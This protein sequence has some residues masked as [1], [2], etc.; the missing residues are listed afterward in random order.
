MEPNSAEPR[1]GALARSPWLRPIGALVAPGA[2][3]RALRDR[4][5][6]VAP[7]LVLLV[8]YV[9]LNLT[10]MQRMDMAAVMRSSMEARGQQVDEQQIQHMAELQGR[11]GLGCSVVGMPVVLLVTALLLMVLVN[12]AGGEATF[13]R[14]WSV[15]LHGL[16][17]M[18]VAWL[19]TL[20][21]VLG[22][23][24]ITLAD[25]Q[26]GLL[27]SNLALLAPADA[28]RVTV[29]LLSSVD[30]FSLWTV[31]LLAY[32]FH[33]ATGAS[34]GAATAVVV[35]L[36]LLAVGLKVGAAAMGFGGA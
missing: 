11:F 14:S 30:L 16:M 27:A 19:L 10:V 5:T 33:R 24:E 13:K 15:T 28:S 18:A 9:L 8:L 17:P 36:W 12:L 1:E 3:F 32:G 25:S 2:T 26:R 34:K 4:P 29:A 23:A 22:R 20:P 35:L 21:V 7:L 31:A 6:W